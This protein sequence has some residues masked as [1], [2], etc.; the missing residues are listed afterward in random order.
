MSGI[1]GGDAGLRAAQDV[2]AHGAMVAR[3]NS[4]AHG[5][6]AEATDAPA[7]EGVGMKNTA[8]RMSAT[9]LDPL[10]LRRG[11]GKRAQP[12][13]HCQAKTRL[14]RLEKC[15]SAHAAA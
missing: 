1:S 11:Q 15:L 8:I 5:L 7:G 4:T 12:R 10:V 9:L 3:G 13:R 2:V 14:T 6:P